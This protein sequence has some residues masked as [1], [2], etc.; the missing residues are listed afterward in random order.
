MPPPTVPVISLPHVMSGWLYALAEE[1]LQDAL[2][3]FAKRAMKAAY[4]TT[5]P[6][7][8]YNKELARRQ[9]SIDDR[10]LKADQLRADLAALGT[11]ST[12]AETDQ[13]LPSFPVAR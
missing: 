2:D 8:L 11:P 13:V 1:L 7:D 3:P 6:D 9:K 10:S 5:D 12:P 4:S